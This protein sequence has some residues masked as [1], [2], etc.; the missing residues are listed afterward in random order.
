MGHK[1]GDQSNRPSLCTILKKK[2]S[3]ALKYF[4][5]VETREKENS[6]FRANKKDHKCEGTKSQIASKLV[7]VVKVA[8]IVEQCCM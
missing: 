7:A 8:E 6:K 2:K 4:Q 3:N 1:R 5:N